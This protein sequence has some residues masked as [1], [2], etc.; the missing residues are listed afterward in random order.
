VA[1]PTRSVDASLELPPPRGL[2]AYT[3]NVGNEELLILGFALP[4]IVPPP[5]LTAAEEEVVRAVASGMKNAEI[6]RRRGTSQRTVAN[7]LTSIFQ[8]LGITSR[9]QLVCMSTVRR[10]QGEE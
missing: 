7:Q 5:G 1:A 9:A 4:R 8:K 10:T 2:E 3:V 6:A